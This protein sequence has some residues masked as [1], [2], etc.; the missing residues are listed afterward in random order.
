MAETAHDRLVR[1]LGIVTYLEANG[2]TEFSVLARHFGVP[3]SRIR[4]DIDVLWGSSSDRY[5][6]V[7]YVDFD[8]DSFD[9]DVAKLTKDQGLTQVRLSSREAVALVVSLSSLATAQVAPGIVNQVLSKLRGAL[10]E[11]VTVI[12]EAPHV[13]QEVTPALLDAI[14]RYRRV[15]VTYVDAQDRRTTRDVDPHRLVAIDSV[16]YLECYCW[17]ANDYRT[18]RLDRI[19][20]VEGDQGSVTSAPS[21]TAGFALRRR[22][23]ATVT[24]ARA[25]RYAVEVIPGVTIEEQGDDVVAHFDVSDM[26]WVA[27]QLLAIAPHLRSVAPGELHDALLA[28]AQA[29]AQAQAGQ[30]T[31]AKEPRQG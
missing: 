28:Q 8:S 29:V 19:E 16:A 27:G 15:T 11:P 31:T 17:R 25:G 7:L 10:S 24:L 18:L 14:R 23:R 26:D 1:L 21:D 9:Q 3:D 4:T 2:P 12:D 20:A 5:D 22:S 30:A 13:S 6:P